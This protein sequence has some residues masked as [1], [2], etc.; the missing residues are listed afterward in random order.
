MLDGELGVAHVGVMLL[1][2]GE[3]GQQLG[4]TGWEDQLHVVEIFGVTDAGDD[5]F[6]LC[7]DEEVAIGLVVAGGSVTGE[8]H[9]RA[10]VLVPVAEHHGLHVDGS[11]QVVADAL[12][13]AIG[14]GASAVPAGEHGLDCAAQLF[15]RL[16][17]ERL[18]GDLLDGGLVLLAQIFQRLGRKFGIGLH[19]SGGLGL[20]QRVL[21]VLA[22]DA[23]DNAAVHGDE[24]AIAVV[25][26]ALV[27]GDVGQTLDAFVVQ[28]Q[29]ED[30]VHHA[31][32]GEFGAGANRHEQRV[33]RI[34]QL[35]THRF[36][37][38]EHLRGNLFVEALRPAAAHV[39]PAGVGGNG[40]ARGHR[41]LQYARHLCEVR[42]LSAKEIFVLHGRAAVLVIEGVDV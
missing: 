21:E 30:R 17:R 14:D 27:V 6:A 41:Q 40:E 15:A 38:L 26:E 13:H 31:G 10:A 5:V 19:T 22:I 32:H 37:Q 11:S 25:R 33:V 18:L 23:Q 24:A 3:D 8:A 34:A 9:A 4:M 16:L 29:V 39:G 35:S 28:A 42:A 20:L 12:P 2:A 1:E 7:V 36:F